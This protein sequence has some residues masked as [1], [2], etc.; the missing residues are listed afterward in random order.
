MRINGFLAVAALAAGLG[1]GLGALPAQ[2]EDDGG[3]LVEFKAMKPKVALEMAQAAMQHCRDGGYQ[4]AVAVT[5]RWGNVQVL[6]RDRLAGPHTIETSRRKAWTAASFRTATKDLDKETRP[7]SISAGIRL[8]SEALPL[9]GG[10]PVQAAGTM[11]GAVGVS[12]APSPDI[13]HECAQAGLD[14]VAVE[15]Q[16]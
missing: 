10:I 13:D 15:L 14:A 9:G 7:D 16:F 8:L 2:A 1:T 3:A 5:D 6:L 4:V 11:V 12:G